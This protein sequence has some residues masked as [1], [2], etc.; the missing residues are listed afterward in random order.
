MW[1]DCEG[2]GYYL[3][4]RKPQHCEPEFNRDGLCF[5]EDRNLTCMKDDDGDGMFTIRTHVEQGEKSRWKS[6]MDEVL[7]EV[8]G[9]H[10]HLFVRADVGLVTS[11]D[12]WQRAS[13]NFSEDK[14]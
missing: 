14:V 6:K 12:T 1:S 5:G 8:D 2:C 4:E 3:W 11:P 10:V 7:T 13:P 9:G